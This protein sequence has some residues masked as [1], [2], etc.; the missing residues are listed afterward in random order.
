MQN[1]FQDEPHLKNISPEGLKSMA[2]VERFVKAHLNDDYET[3]L[4]LLCDVITI[5][6]SSHL[7][8]PKKELPKED[9]LNYHQELRRKIEVIEY[10]IS[11]VYADA[12]TVFILGNKTERVHKTGLL[13]NEKCIWIYTI[14]ADLI[15]KIECMK[16][17]HPL[18]IFFIEIIERK[19]TN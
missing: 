11:K 8:H 5:D 12:N 10:N 1:F 3:R 17:C 19:K 4:K 2:L 7:G 16:P 14:E 6:Y 15:K 13:F 9:A 18:Y